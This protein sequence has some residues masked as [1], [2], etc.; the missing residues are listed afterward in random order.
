MLSTSLS[1][2]RRFLRYHGGQRGAG[3]AWIG[4]P[5]LFRADADAHF[6]LFVHLSHCHSPSW[7]KN[8]LGDQRT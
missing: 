2:G 6:L 3:H 1:P 7:S 8:Q 5:S 4:F